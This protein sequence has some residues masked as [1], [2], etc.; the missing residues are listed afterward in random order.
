MIAV[1]LWN[2]WKVLDL[3]SAKPA[4]TS[5]E[6]HSLIQHR[7]SPLSF[8]PEPLTKL[9]I[10]QICEAARWAPSSY[11][12]QPWSFLLAPRDDQAAFEKLLGCLME[13][14]QSWAKNCGLLVLAVAR[15]TLKKTGKPNKFGLH[16]TGMAT[17]S[18]M[19]QAEA[20]GLRAH[21][22]GGFNA[23]HARA[24][25]AIPENCELASVIAF[26]HPGDA[27]NLPD[28]LRTRDASSRERQ[29]LSQMAF[30]GKFG[31][32]FPLP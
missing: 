5:V 20:L 29:P 21:A 9:Q 3:M 12:D 19:L 4:P 16:D 24:M 25:Y 7:W 14:N 31:E 6:I 15:T 27:S 13:A 23:V 18:M 28:D 22:M 17:F 1:N 8:R 11:N 30:I 26:G 10:I 2:R 32:P